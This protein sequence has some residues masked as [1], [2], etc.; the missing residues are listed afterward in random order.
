[1]GTEARIYHTQIPMKL[2][3]P[4]LLR[5]AVLAALLC[6]TTAFG[7][8]TVTVDSQPSSL[9]QLTGTPSGSVSITVEGENATLT[10]PLT[11]DGSTGHYITV[12]EGNSLTIKGGL[13][14]DSE[15]EDYYGELLPIYD[16]RLSLL[17]GA[18][19]IFASGESKLV[20][21]SNGFSG[22]A[23][24]IVVQKGAKLTLMYAH[25]TASVG[26]SVEEGGELIAG[27]YVYCSS[28]NGKGTLRFAGG[29]EDW[30]DGDIS[31]MGTGGKFE[32]IVEGRGGIDIWGQPFQSAEQTFFNVT[33]KE[34]E[35]TTSC[36]NIILDGSKNEFQS[37]LLGDVFMISPGVEGY[38]DSVSVP[39]VT[40]TLTIKEGTKVTI[41]KV[42]LTSEDYSSDPDFGEFWD[43]GIG[44]PLI[45]R[46]LSFRMEDRSQLVMKYGKGETGAKI[47][48]SGAINLT[49]TEW[50]GHDLTRLTVRVEFAENPGKDLKQ[51]LIQANGIVLTSMWYN[52]TGGMYSE[53]YTTTFTLK[54]QYTDE[55]SE[56]D[57]NK[58][59]KENVTVTVNGYD[60]PYL[61]VEKKGGRL[62]QLYVV[63]GDGAELP[64]DPIDSG[65]D[66]SKPDNPGTD[67]PGTDTP[68]TDTPGTDTP[69]T[70]TPGTDTPGTDTPG[71]DTPGT[72]TPGTDTP[73]TDTPKPS[74]PDTVFAPLATSE[75]EQVGAGMLYHAMKHST[76]SELQEVVDVIGQLAQIG[77]GGQPAVAM[78]A[79]IDEPGAEMLIRETTIDPGVARSEAQKL[80][81]AV[82]GSS[83]PALGAAQRDAMRGQLSLAKS[84]AARLGQEPVTQGDSEQGMHV[85]M[86]GMGGIAKLDRSGDETGYEHNSWG[87]G[88]GMEKAF[89]GGATTV[90]FSL[91]ASY[92]DLEVDAADHAEGDMDTYYVNLY[93]H[94]RSGN[95]HHS[96]VVSAGFSDAEFNR[97]IRGGVA[98]YVLNYDTNGST[99]GT[100]FGAA[101][102]LAYDISLNERK[103]CL[104]QPMVGVSFITTKMNG[105]DE[106]GIGGDA[107]L[108]VGDQESTL[109]TLTAGARLLAQCGEHTLG[110]A[111]LLE[112]RANVAVDMGDRRS[113]AD[114]SFLGDRSYSGR[115]RSAET[116]VVGA[117]LGAGLSV[118]VSGNTLIYVNGEADLRSGTNS[119][120]VGAG[121]SV[122]F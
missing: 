69:G 82:V 112:L 87:A 117:Q 47:T 67:T 110:R 14:Y 20:G 76:S 96:F 28:L 90:G 30:Y 86:E 18:Q 97:I 39:E 114:V 44:T 83:V 46:G 73:G 119:W 68:G 2:H 4:H 92:G 77:Q 99:D 59:L 71:T 32:G 9:E 93:A 50:E 94:H 65:T 41:G 7:T 107:G 8:V 106:G 21:I 79:V 15:R 5:N 6:C 10:Q 19:I 13:T 45:Q 57:L 116:G 33:A 62:V 85:W 42:S 64:D 113:K 75:N 70:D 26:L 52:E 3:L 36:G 27:D 31:I 78:A 43:P 98:P 100:G 61:M 72:D 103:S 66:D 40:D 53:D 60:D 25:S 105:Y 55:N 23:G 102:E 88:V 24:T 58:W 109:T 37:I 89:R 118:P 54:E 1:M 81:S 22:D 80:M 12:D 95:F 34:T 101:Y 121:A 16:L 11:L 74:N 38:D 122:A 51:L 115:V 104:L 120:N 48:A 49:T 108:H 84:R 91:V 111:A 29:V 17:N 56:D 35:L 63:A